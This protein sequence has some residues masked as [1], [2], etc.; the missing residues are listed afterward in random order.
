MYAASIVLQ[1]SFL[2]LR[3]LATF[4]RKRNVVDAPWIYCVYIDH[5]DG[6]TKF[7]KTLS[8]QEF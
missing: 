2:N 5:V 3:H 6:L 8:P 4:A 7:A 1:H